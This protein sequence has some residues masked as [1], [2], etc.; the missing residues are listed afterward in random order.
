MA[1][2]DLERHQ[3]CDLKTPVRN[4]YFYGKLLDVFHFEMEQQYF[5]SK[6]WLLNR[7]VTGPGVVCG[8]DVKLT[9]DNR[10]VSVEPGLAI[11]R[12]GR[13]IIVPEAS[14]PEALPPLPPYEHDSPKQSRQSRSQGRLERHDYCAED[15]AHVVLCRH[16]CPSDP[17]PVLAGDCEM[18]VCAAGSIRERYKVEVRGGHAP[19]RASNFPD[20]ITG[21]RIN[22]NAIVEYVTRP[23][24]PLPEDCCIPLA[25]VLLRDTGQGWEPEIDIN[26]RPIV[27]TNRL[28]YDLLISL[29]KEESEV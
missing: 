12:C 14:R 28:L 11:D 1:Q 7:L 2:H 5:N 3:H 29:L 25:N 27:Y 6:R 26:C 4:R 24:R 20:V 15:Y 8:L 19:E 10:C 18:E 17:T 23:C 13:E 9:P 21:R 16:E 22:Y